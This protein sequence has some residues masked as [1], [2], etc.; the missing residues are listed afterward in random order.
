[1]NSWCSLAVFPF[2]PKYVPLSSSFSMAM[3]AAMVAEDAV[4]V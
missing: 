4:Y 2:V 3:D 1:M